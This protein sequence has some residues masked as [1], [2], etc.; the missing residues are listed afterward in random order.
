[1]F[2]IGLKL[3]RYLKESLDIGNWD[4]EVS[5]PIQ[6]KEDQSLIENPLIETYTQ[7]PCSTFK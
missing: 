2:E 4:F 7:K 5:E 6:I 3:L 1:M